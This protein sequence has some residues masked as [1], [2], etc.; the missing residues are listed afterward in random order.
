MFTK[1]RLGLA[2]ENFCLK[3][4]LFPYTLLGGKGMVLLWQSD[5]VLIDSWHVMCGL[6]TA[7]LQKFWMIYFVFLCSLQTYYATFSE[8]E[9]NERDDKIAFQLQEFFCST[10]V[11]ECTFPHLNRRY[12]RKH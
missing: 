10:V 3:V 8:T 4:F 9:N 2:L 7:P 1:A 5:H 6:K 12:V 11:Y